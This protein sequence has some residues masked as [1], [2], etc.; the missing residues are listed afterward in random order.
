MQYR[1]LKFYY[2]RNEYW[3]NDNYGTINLPQ[4][5]KY[6]RKYNFKV[7][8]KQNSLPTL[9]QYQE[10]VNSDEY[11]IPMYP[12]NTK[13]NNDIFDKYL[14]EITQMKNICPI[15]SLYLYLDMDKAIALSFDMLPLIETYL[16]LSSTEKYQRIKKIRENY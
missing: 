3:E 15:L 5:P 7:F 12:I 9:I 11:N 14:R 6:I 1:S 16:K 13:V 2:R 10:S 8:H 4:H